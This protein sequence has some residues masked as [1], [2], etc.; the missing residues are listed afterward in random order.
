MNNG[1]F[2]L[3]RPLFRSCLHHFQQRVKSK[4]CCSGICAIIGKDLVRGTPRKLCRIVTLYEKS[5]SHII[6]QV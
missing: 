2:K 6:W 3:N 4:T 1:A 5:H